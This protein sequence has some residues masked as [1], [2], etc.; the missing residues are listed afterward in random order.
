MLI[1]VWTQKLTECIDKIDCV[2][3]ILIPF[4]AFDFPL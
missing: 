2:D 4:R 3:M 1:V